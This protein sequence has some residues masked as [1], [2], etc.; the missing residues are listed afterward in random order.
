[1]TIYLMHMK[2]AEGLTTGISVLFGGAVSI[3]NA[4]S[5]SLQDEFLFTA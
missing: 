5:S 2:V 4:V 1:M 3:G